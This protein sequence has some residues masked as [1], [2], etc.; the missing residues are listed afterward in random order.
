MH[1]QILHQFLGK[2]SVVGCQIPRFLYFF[3]NY[4]FK[5]SS[6]ICRIVFGLSLF[7][8]SEV[9]NF[10]KLDS[11]LQGNGKMKG[12]NKTEDASL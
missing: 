1:L 10:L 11:D 6:D 2:L 5:N 12:E 3:Q 4:P 9:I 7:L 8:H